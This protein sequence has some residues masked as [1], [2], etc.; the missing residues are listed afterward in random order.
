MRVVLDPSAADHLVETAETFASLQAA[1]TD[2]RLEVLLPDTA[3][4]E[5]AATPDAERLGRLKALA[6]L[7][8][9]VQ[10]G[11][12]VIGWSAVG[13]HRIGDKSWTDTLRQSKEQHNNDAV[14]AAVTM[15]DDAVLVTED[16]RQARQ[17]QLLMRRAWTAQQLVSRL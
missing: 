15:F 2:G 5:L 12:M 7:C 13:R 4:R 8:A 3:R 11:G 6:E 9:P 17:T 16:H 14:I 10:D 1:I